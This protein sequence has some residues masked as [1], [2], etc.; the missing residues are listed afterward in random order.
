[1]SSLRKPMRITVRG[2]NEREYMFLVK[3][4]EDLRQDQRVEQV[5]AFTLCHTL[6][7]SWSTG[8]LMASFELTSF[9]VC[10]TRCLV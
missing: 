9:Y 4:G 7:A 5:L 8:L 10:V 3:G 6:Y 1:M 2:D